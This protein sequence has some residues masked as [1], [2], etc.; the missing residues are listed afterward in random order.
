MMKKENMKNYF[1]PTDE[2]ISIFIE[3]KEANIRIESIISE[4]MEGMIRKWGL[5]Y[6]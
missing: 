5:S 1:Q 4:E 3:Y 2:S 6:N